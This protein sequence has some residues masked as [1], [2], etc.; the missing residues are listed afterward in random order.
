MFLWRN[1]KNISFPLEKFPGFQ[2][3]PTFS[4]FFVLLLFP[5]CFLKMPYCPYFLIRKGKI[6]AKRSNSVLNE[7]FLILGCNCTSRLSVQSFIIP[8]AKQSFSGV[9]CFQHVCD[10]LILSF[11][12][13]CNQM[14]NSS[15]SLMEKTV[16]SL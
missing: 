4:Y 1:K 8:P 7:A 11:H 5:Y 16:S 6:Y 15:L 13:I 14:V 12:Q 3:G 2:V 10:F 9:Y